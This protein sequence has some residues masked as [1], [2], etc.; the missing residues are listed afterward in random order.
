MPNVVDA[1]PEAL[2]SRYVDIDSMPWV[3]MSERSFRKV[4]VRRSGLGAL[5]LAH[6]P[7]ARHAG[8]NR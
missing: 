6:A 1:I 4:L 2:R 7:I 8:G 5:Y 3:Q